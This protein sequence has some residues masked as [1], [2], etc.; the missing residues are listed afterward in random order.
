MLHKVLQLAGKIMGRNKLSILIYHQVLAEPDPMRPSEPTA[1]VF[2]WHMCLLHN[3]FTPLSLDQALEHLQQNTL[4]ANAVCVTFDDGYLNNLTVAQPILAK[5][6]IPA[7]VYI[8]TGFSAGTN[9]WNDRVIYLFA[10][11]NREQLN[12]QGEKVMLGDW[13][14]RRQLAQ[15]WLMKLKY[16]PIDQRLAE[17]DKLYRENETAEQASLMMTPEEIKRL[18]ATGICIGAHTINHPI[19]KVLPATEQQYEIMHSKQQL[20]Q[21]TGQAV[22]HFAYPNGVLGRDFDE[23]AVQIVSQAGFS[24]AVATNWGV[25]DGKCSFFKLRRFTPWDNSALKFHARLVNN[26]RQSQPL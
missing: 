17:V 14:Q 9:M 12:L 11:K 16:L 3:Y 7:T 15:Q 25:S 19:L 4:P 22:K 2:D 8:A 23:T 10:D 1:A 20:E 5:Y 18:S 24:T 6:D 13:Q 26:M 21:W